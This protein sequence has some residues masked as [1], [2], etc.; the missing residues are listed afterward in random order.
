MSAFCEPVTRTSMPSRSIGRSSTPTAVM[1]STTS[2]VSRLRV[3]S[4]IAPTGWSA[5]VDVSL[6]CM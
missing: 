1:P 5:H 4:A 2:S 6:A 3:S